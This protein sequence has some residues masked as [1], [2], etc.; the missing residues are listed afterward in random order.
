VNERW[1]E[2]E[3]DE[4]NDNNAHHETGE[5]L[6]NSDRSASI[7][8]LSPY[9]LACRMLNHIGWNGND[10]R[11]RDK[12]ALAIAPEVERINKKT[13]KENKA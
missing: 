1:P 9:E 3:I 2:E 4:W 13:E 11:L 5:M 8:P 6:D 10:F 12:V 7:E